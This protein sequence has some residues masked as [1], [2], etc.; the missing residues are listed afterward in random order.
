[1]ER[2]YLLP[3]GSD[4][5]TKQRLW[6]K[7]LFC[8]E[9]KERIETLLAFYSEATSNLRNG[10]GKITLLRNNLER[11]MRALKK[12]DEI[13]WLR[14]LQ[15]YRAADSAWFAS[16]V[17]SVEKYLKSNGVYE[18]A[19]ILSPFTHS[20]IQFFLGFGTRT[21]ND[22]RDAHHLYIKTAR[23]HKI[24]IEKDEWYAMVITRKQPPKLFCLKIKNRSD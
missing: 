3:G 17:Y 10:D 18:R 9:G 7:M 2:P 24:R 1:M 11:V 19:K 14:F 16:G 21:E 23:R 20:H 12:R 5:E 13:E 15:A 22:F 6:R 8:L 4:Y